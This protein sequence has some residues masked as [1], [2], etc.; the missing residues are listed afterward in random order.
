MYEGWETD[1]LDVRLDDDPSL[2][3]HE[4]SFDILQ[5]VDVDNCEQYL[6]VS[7]DSFLEVPLQESE[8]VCSAL[9]SNDNVVSVD[10]QAVSGA[11]V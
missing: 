3:L 5:G 1:V 11:V 10:S 2:P 4:L 7:H 6:N 8:P 9:L